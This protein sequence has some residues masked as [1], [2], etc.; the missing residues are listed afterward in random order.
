MSSRAA[1]ASSRAHLAG[2]K[3]IHWQRQVPC[4]ESRTNMEARLRC[5]H[6]CQPESEK[7][8]VVTPNLSSD[9]GTRL[10]HPNSLLSCATDP[11]KRT[12][13]QCHTMGF[14]LG[15]AQG[16]PSLHSLQPGRDMLLQVGQGGLHVL[17]AAPGTCFKA[18]FLK[19][20][21]C[22]CSCRRRLM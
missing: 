18:C 16:K 22:S 11:A 14:N 12:E 7:T 6:S 19:Y 8:F 5:Q 21:K 9:V 2:L 3:H 1:R 10:L 20:S 13:A 4:C 17:S 15:S